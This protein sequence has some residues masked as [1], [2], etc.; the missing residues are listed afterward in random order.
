MWGSECFWSLSE[1]CSTVSEQ[2]TGRLG[3]QAKCGEAPCIG[4]HQQ[5]CIPGPKIISWLGSNNNN[6][7]N[8]DGD[9]NNNSCSNTAI[10]LVMKIILFIIELHFAETSTNI[11]WYLYSRGPVRQVFSQRASYEWFKLRKKIC[12]SKGISF[13][14]FFLTEIS[15]WKTWID[16]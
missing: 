1:D 10:E 12:L 13:L 4:W 7:N 3:H 8:K 11:T 5:S 9:D 6:N 15:K 14:R 2:L 16:L